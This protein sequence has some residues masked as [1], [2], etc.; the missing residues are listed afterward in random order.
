MQKK[1]F[2]LAGAVK[3]KNLGVTKI[4]A[5]RMKRRLSWTLRIRTGG[6]LEEFQEHLT[7]VLEHHF[8]NYDHC[9]DWCKAKG[10]NDEFMEEDKLRQLFHSWDTNAVEGFNKLITKF[11]PKARTFYKTLENAIRIHLACCL[12]S[13]G[14][15]ET[16]RCVF[17]IAGISIGDF[18]RLYLR[19]EDM[20]QIWRR[21]HRKKLPVKVMR[22]T[23]YYSK[24]RE[25][26]MKQAEDGKKWLSYESGMMGPGGSN[27]MTASN[28]NENTKSNCCSTCGLTSHWRSTSRQ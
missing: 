10:M 17:A 5:E 22:M 25:E 8:N 18:N 2:L 4:D 26:K 24:A 1:Y 13:I 28:K 9:G 21:K 15:R 14:Y 27:P 7:A 16:Y 3:A 11:L 6:T 12:L 19:L 20:E 23:K